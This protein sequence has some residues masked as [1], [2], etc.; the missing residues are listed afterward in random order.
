MLEH[1]KDFIFSYFHSNSMFVSTVGPESEKV[2]LVTSYHRLKSN[3]TCKW[4]EVRDV[5][6]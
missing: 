3:L 2:S 1:T 5:R 4:L 6:G